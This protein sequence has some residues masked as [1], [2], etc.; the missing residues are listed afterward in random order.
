MAAAKEAVGKLIDK[1]PGDLNVAVIVYGVSK[2][3][4]CEDID[5]VQ[6][7]GP[8]DRASLK[9]KLLSLPNS[10]MT[11]IAGSLE[12]AGL[13]LQ[14]AKGG[15]AIILV[16]DGV[17]SCKGD[18]STVAA[19]LAT[20]FGVKFGLHVIGFDINPNERAGLE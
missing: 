11:P 15:R 12:I 16:T 9:S 18:P 20:E 19:Q 8:V 3:R 7:L 4:G 14:K 6:P 2:S 17:E 13:A 1:L 5:L 10:G